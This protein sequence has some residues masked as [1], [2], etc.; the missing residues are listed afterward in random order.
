MSSTGQSAGAMSVGAQ[1]LANDGNTEGLFH[2]AFMESGA[3]SPLGDITN[4]QYVYNNIVRKLGCLGAS[5][6]LQCLREAS[7]EDIK[8][9]MDATKSFLSS[10]VSKM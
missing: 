1:M 4:G 7:F 5:D 9:A 3:I 2:A 10:M 6:S 8:E